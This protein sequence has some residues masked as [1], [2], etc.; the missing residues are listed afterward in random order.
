MQ[1]PATGSPSVTLMLGGDVMTGR[2]IDQALPHPCDPRLYEPYVSSA[3]HYLRLA[4]DA[5]GPIP[6]AAEDEYIWGDAL[7][8]C[9]REGAHARIVNLE[10]SV[11][12]SDD[13][14]DKG[15]NYRM[16]P[17]NVGVLTAAEIDCCALANNHVL[18]WGEAGLLETIETLQ[19]VGVRHAGAGRQLRRGRSP[20]DRPARCG[21][22]GRVLFCDR[23]ERRAAELAGSGRHAGDRCSGRPLAVDS[24]PRGRAG[25]SAQTPPGTS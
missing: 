22:C 13:A 19:R 10:T 1:G 8:N 5:N 7:E 2:G 15:I 21:A 14:V 4:E 12:T 6:R 24:G 23:V 16:H 3:R 25:A 18:D 20:R 9:R 17:E 11:T